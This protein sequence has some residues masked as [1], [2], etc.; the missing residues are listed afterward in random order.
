MPY[1]MIENLKIHYRVVGDISDQT[2]PTFIFLHGGAGMADHS[3][4]VSF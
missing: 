2:K 4:Y 3:I 1:V